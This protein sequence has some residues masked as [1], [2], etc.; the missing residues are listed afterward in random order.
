MEYYVPAEVYDNLV[1]MMSYRKLVVTSPILSHTDVAHALN[2]Q[3]YVLITGTRDESNTQ[4][5]ASVY[6]VLIAPNS[7]YA[8]AS[9]DFKKL[10]K[11]VP[12]DEKLMEIIFVSEYV[13]TVHIKKQIVEFKNSSGVH[14]ENYDYEIFMME[15][16]K[17]ISVPKHV[18]A[19]TEE[20]NTFCNC[21]HTTKAYF[22]KILSTDPQA[23][24]LGLRP[25][26]CVKIIRLSETAGNAVAYRLCV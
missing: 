19:T 8:K 11:L 18:I 4:L 7:K 16:P 15:V 26:M 17:H 5:S 25:G 12:K 13:L 3:E 21:Y 9:A 1:K 2:Q 23:V 10:F 22:P 6:V 14:V 20:I 24:W